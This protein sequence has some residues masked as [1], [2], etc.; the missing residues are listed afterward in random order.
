MSQ[1]KVY[2]ALVTLANYWGYYLHYINIQLSVLKAGTSY[3]R[4]YMQSAKVVLLVFP[5]WCNY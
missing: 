1:N 4:H 2:Y 5:E 3:M